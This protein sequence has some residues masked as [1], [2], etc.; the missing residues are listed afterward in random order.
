MSKS[1]PSGCVDLRISSASLPL[2][3]RT[4][5]FRM[6]SDVVH[7]KGRSVVFAN[8]RVSKHPAEAHYVTFKDF[9]L[10]GI[11]DANARVGEILAAIA[12]SGLAELIKSGSIEATIVFGAFKGE[13]DWAG[14]LDPALRTAA[15]SANVGVELA[16]YEHYDEEGRPLAVTLVQRSR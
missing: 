7:V 8:G 2:A 12:G 5:G 14:G 3:D 4:A 10:D 15:R 6:E 13:I 1:V 16:D 9:A 11:P